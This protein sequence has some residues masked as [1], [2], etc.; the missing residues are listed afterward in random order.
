MSAPTETIPAATLILFRARAGHEPDLL[1][2]ERGAGMAFAAGALVF[3]GGRI[4]LGDHALAS[5]FA[6]ECGEDEMLAA[7]IAAI[8]ET[9]E[10]VGVAVGLTPPP[11]ATTIATLR[12]GLAAG[13]DFAA[14][15]AE[16][17]LGVDA[18]ALAPFARWRP[19]TNQTRN[20]DTMFFVAAAPVGAV[21]IADGGESVRA[22]WASATSLLADADAGRHRLIFPTRRNLERLVRL[23]SIEAA[24]A[25]A[26]G[27][28]IAPIT[29]W[30]EDRGGERWLCIP[31]DS[32]YPITAER[33]TDALRG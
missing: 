18:S 14:L 25:H 26:A 2:I 21:A 7:R 17:G 29:P 13:R 24:Q 33:L 6:A 30:I 10:E 16:A 5:T 23:A 20:F 19:D 15:L 28:A 12:A 1:M 4:D 9:I 31:E 22:V 11:D 27:H 3:P 32:G 8:R